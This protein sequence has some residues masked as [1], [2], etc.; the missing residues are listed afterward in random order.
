MNVVFEIAE[1]AEEGSAVKV[2]I[3]YSG[4]D[5]TIAVSGLGEGI[6]ETAKAQGRSV[7]EI[8]DSVRI[9]SSM[10]IKPAPGKVY[11]YAGVIVEGQ[12]IPK[13]W[14]VADT[15]HIIVEIDK[16]AAKDQEEQL[17]QMRAQKELMSTLVNEEKAD[18]AAELVEGLVEQQQQVDN[19]GSMLI[20]HPQANSEV[21][22][23]LAQMMAAHAPAAAA[24]PIQQ[25]HAAAAA[26]NPAAV[27]Q[28]SRFLPCV[29]RHWARSPAPGL[30][31]PSPSPPCS[32]PHTNAPRPRLA[33]F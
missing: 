2:S 26:A 19:I 24:A 6:L 16:Q 11:C 17:S 18:E 20:M 30:L 12:E 3:V 22:D 13:P 27:Q 33:A 5:S 14:E 28:A 4:S 7:V 10:I 15:T 29:T 8:I 32:H 25:Q 23:E 21:D 31:L 9:N 1:I